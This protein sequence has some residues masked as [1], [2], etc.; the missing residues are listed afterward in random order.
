MDSH[1]C[2]GPACMFGEGEHTCFCEACI[3]QLGE[4]TCSCVPCML[5]VPEE[6]EELEEE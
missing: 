4:H 2:N 3:E 5:G 6:V 1:T